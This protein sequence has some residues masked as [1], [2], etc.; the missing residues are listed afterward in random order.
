MSSNVLT[1]VKMDAQPVQTGT[2][3]DPGRAGAADGKPLPLSGQARPNAPRPGA[4][5]PPEVALP[6]PADLSRVV[7]RLDQ[8]LRENAR[9]LQFR[10]DEASG[11]T[12][13]TVLDG[14]TGNV[15]RQIPSEEVLAMAERLQ[16]PAQAGSLLDLRA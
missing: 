8:F 6:P 5:P 10:I 9:N 16:S 1:G 13:V 12:V 2:R 14:A 11:R 7:E 4:P 15:V 3:S